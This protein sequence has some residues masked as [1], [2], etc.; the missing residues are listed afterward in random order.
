MSYDFD[1]FQEE[2]R[3]SL[4]AARE[5][6]PA[7]LRS[8][9]LHT[10][11]DIGCGVG[12]WVTTAHEHGL[13]AVGVDLIP[14]NWRQT[15]HIIQHDLI[16]G[17]PCTNW[18]IAI[19]LEVAE[20]LPETSA[21]RLVEGLAMAGCVLFSAATP[22]QPG[23]DHVNCQPHEYWHDKFAQYGFTPTHW[24]ARFPTIADFYQRNMYLY[25]KAAS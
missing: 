2:G 14:M 20:H 17:F 10:L 21:D 7:L 8:R 25:E 22:G 12:T 19:C 1:F 18:D 16:R 6:I 23:V 3:V 5:V 13:T 4:E 15:P 9:A 11:I 24:G